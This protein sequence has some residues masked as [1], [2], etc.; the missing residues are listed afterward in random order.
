MPVEQLPGRLLIGRQIGAA[1]AEDRLLGI[2]HQKE[3][4][5]GGEGVSTG[6]MGFE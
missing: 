1:E 6:E 3:N 2:A 5:E 4:G